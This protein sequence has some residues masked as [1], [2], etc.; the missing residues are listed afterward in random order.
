MAGQIPKKTQ[1]L[2]KMESRDT[3]RGHVRQR[4]LLKILRSLADNA[5]LP[6]QSDAGG[7]IDPFLNGG[8]HLQYLGGEMCIRDR[9]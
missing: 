5:N 8:D 4:K 6:L 2:D 3:A 9:L 1:G 7:G